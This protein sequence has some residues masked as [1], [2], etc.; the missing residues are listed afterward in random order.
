MGAKPTSVLAMVQLPLGHPRAQR[1]VMRD[2]M[3]GSLEELRRMD[4]TIVGGHTIEGPRVTIGFTVLGHQL[5]E[6][7]TKGMLRPGDQLIL[8]KPLG[9]G[10]WLLACQPVFRRHLRLW[11][12][13]DRYLRNSR[14]F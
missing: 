7:K 6:P 11:S 2:L 1:Q 13:Y 14:C 12:G 8:S 4:A 3:A 9:T 10:C 5:C